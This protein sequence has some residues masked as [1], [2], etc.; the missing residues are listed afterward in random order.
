MIN[1]ILYGDETKKVLPSSTLH[2]IEHF[3]S[4]YV[5]LQ[6]KMTSENVF[7]PFSQ[8]TTRHYAITRWDV[9]KPSPTDTPGTSI[10]KVFQVAIPVWKRPYNEQRCVKE[11]R[12]DSLKIFFFH[13]CI[14]PLIH[15]WFK[16][17]GFDHFVNFWPLLM[18][19]LP[20]FVVLFLYLL[21]ALQIQL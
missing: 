7:G 19:S 17:F 16:N 2:W 13:K 21:H 15:G 6:T 18:I 20:Q 12:H 9:R 1:S 3:Y 8:D 10:Q 5:D 11:T 4:A 14:R